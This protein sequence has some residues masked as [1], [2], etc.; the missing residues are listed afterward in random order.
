MFNTSRRGVNRKKWRELTVRQ[1]KTPS[2]GPGLNG[3]LSFGREAL[4]VD[5]FH[6]QL[7]LRVFA[8]AVRMGAT[9]GETSFFFSNSQGWNCTPPEALIT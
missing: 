8:A 7:V 6:H 5:Q 9:A 3:R 4:H 2:W 1:Q